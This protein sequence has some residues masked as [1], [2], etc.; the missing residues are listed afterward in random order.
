[1]DDPNALSILHV[2]ASGHVGG[3]ESVVKALALG[4][5]ERGHHVGVVAILDLEPA[6]HPFEL[7]LARA[8]LP[9]TP[10]RLPPRAYL[11]ERRCL[12]EHFLRAA[13]QVVHTHGYR[14]DVQGGSVA[15]RL[16]IAT[17]S[18]VHGF[19]GGDWKNRLYERLQER[20][21]RRCDAVIVVAPALVERLRRRGVAKERIHL[22]RNAWSGASELWSR[23]Q[24]RRDLELPQQAWIAGWVGRVSREKGADIL[25]E[26]LAEPEALSIEACI[27]GDGPER[28]ALEKRASR[29]G[30]GARVRWAG[31]RAE[32]ARLFP[33]FDAFVLSSRT[34]GTPIALFEAMAAE[35]PI[36]ATRVGGVPD[37]VGEN[38]AWLVDP[39][40]PEGIVRA[41]AAIRTDPAEARRRCQAARRRLGAGFGLEPWIE[42]HEQL[43]RSLAAHAG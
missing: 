4:L 18:T 6:P 9:V 14:A 25:L 8:D 32:A 16:G 21:L 15:R 30:L 3:L 1:M 27:V 24:A 33:A 34:E 2:L 39:E 40:D 29:L 38:E 42:R 22:V 5:S 31:I 43:Y 12:S 23:D 17:I 37:V 19:T 7:S 10:L 35:V 36:V 28:G 20:A 13:P 11:R 26:A 41:L